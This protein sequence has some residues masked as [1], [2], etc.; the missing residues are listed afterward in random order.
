MGM[1]HA[2]FGIGATLGPLMMTTLIETD[3]SWRLAFVVLAG[4]QGVLAL[5]YV[6]TRVDW[7]VGVD[8]TEG[9]S[10]VRPDRHGLLWGALTMFALYAGVEVGT[11]QWA[12]T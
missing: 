6:R 11:G 10:T 4:A 12:Y 7:N 3:L 5:L 9:S 8:Q 2:G 1:L